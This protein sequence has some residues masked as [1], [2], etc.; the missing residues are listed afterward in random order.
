MNTKLWVVLFILCAL[1][2]I[3]VK[4]INAASQPIIIETYIAPLNPPPDLVVNVT[5]IISD[6]YGL[7]NVSLYYRI[8]GSSFNQVTAKIIEGDYFFGTFQ[9]QIPAQPYGTSVEYYVE[10]EDSIGYVRQ[11]QSS[12]YDIILDTTEPQIISFLM[13]KPVKS[14][15]LP[16]EDV[17]IK[18]VISDESS[19][20]K[21][22]SLFYAFTDYNDQIDPWD[23]KYESIFL[24]KIDG[25]N[26]NGTFFRRY[27]C[28]C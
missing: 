16:N 8:N 28:V 19:G 15:V 5:A 3:N 12:I 25:T 27:S 18:A 24:D 6:N 20:I 9:A 13:T 10:A 23:L 4:T 11:S 1:I 14:P 26:Y 17:T 22:A 7:V 2:T 21:N